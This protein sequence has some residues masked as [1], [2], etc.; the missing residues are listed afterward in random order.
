MRRVEFDPKALNGDQAEWWRKWSARAEGATGRA[1]DAWEEWLQRWLQAKPAKRA[2]MSFDYDI[3]KDSDV[4]SDLKAWL[5]KHIFKGNCAYC[6][7]Q[8]V[9]FY[10]DAEHHRPKG[11]VRVFQN[12]GKLAAVLCDIGPAE[13]TDQIMHPG[14]FWLAFDWKNLVP[15]CEFCNTGE[16]KKD[17][18][19][20][21][22]HVIMRKLNAAQLHR[23]KDPPRQ[24]RKW[25]Q[26]YYLGPADLDQIEKPKLLNPLNPPL[27]RDPAIHLGFGVKGAIFEKANSELGRET[28]RC[29][30]LRQEELRK[31]RQR[32]Q[33]DIH[34]RYFG[35]AAD[36]DSTDADLRRIL[37]PYEAGEEAFSVAALQYLE[38]RRRQFSK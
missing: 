3:S 5:L 15:S 18:Y 13:A 33:E 14:Y 37:A 35:K 6:Q 29:L 27:D 7:I 10:G 9:R 22:R 26:M 21:K 4:W 23:L 19:P 16:G 31:A 2:Q 11:R 17:Q 24:S 20:A 30:H 36:P 8:L 34:R 38:E 1:V 12:D 28:I 32:A 25:P